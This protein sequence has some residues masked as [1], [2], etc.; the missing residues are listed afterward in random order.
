MLFKISSVNYF[1]ISDGKKGIDIYLDEISLIRTSW[2]DYTFF[3]CSA[4]SL[5][6]SKTMLILFSQLTSKSIQTI[7]ATEDRLIAHKFG[8]FKMKSM[9]SNWFKKS[10]I[11]F[12]MLKKRIKWTETLHASLLRRSMPF[13]KESI[14]GSLLPYTKRFKISGSERLT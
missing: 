9:F 6:I 12:L 5:K 10:L 13:V 8:R 1:M 2:Y 4:Y 14:V 7:P 11:I 3:Y